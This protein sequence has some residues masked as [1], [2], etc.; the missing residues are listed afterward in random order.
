MSTP[1]PPLNWN[2]WV[3]Q[4]FGRPGVFNGAMML[5]MLGS[6][7]RYWFGDSAKLSTLYSGTGRSYYESYLKMLNSVATLSRFEVP[8]FDTKNW[9]YLTF[10]ESELQTATKILYGTDNLEYRQSLHPGYGGLTERGEFLLKAPDNLE[11]APVLYNRIVSPSL[12]LQ[13]GTDY[14]LKDGYFRF[15]ANPFE[16]DLVPYRSIL[17]E[18]GEVVDRQIALWVY[19]SEWDLEYVYNHFGYVLGIWMKSSTFYKDFINALWDSMVLG[20]SKLAVLSAWE[21]ISGVEFAKGNETVESIDDDDVVIVKTTAETYSYPAGSNVIVAIGEKLHPGQAIVDTVQIFDQGMFP[22]VFGLS[23]G[24]A[25]LQGEYQAPLVFQNESVSLK[26]LGVLPNNTAWVEFDVSGLQGDVQ[27]FWR[28][29]KRNAALEGRSVASLFDTRGNKTE[30]V[31]PSALPA[32]VN[33]MKFIMENLMDNNT[34]IV[35]VRPGMFRTGALG[36]SATTHLRRHTPPHTTFI[37]LV[38]SQ[39]YEDVID[40]NAALT[41]TVTVNSHGICVSDAFNSV[42]DH[43]PKIRT[44]TEDYI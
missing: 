8:I 14:E 31:P 26:Y 1:K 22:G 11:T 13:A 4:E 6:W 17:D 12:V 9:Y 28:N 3:M 7:W 29:V 38:E 43:G 24:P 21:A 2:N 41:D 39:D 34:Y 33:P 25:L 20:A 19:Q 37:T 5:T 10:L 23:L 30:P 36:L 42:I 27:A 18:N 15:E 16:N 32:T 44:M 40:L 35:S